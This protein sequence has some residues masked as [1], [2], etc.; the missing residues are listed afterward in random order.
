MTASVC[1][2]GR[3]DAGDSE[4][5]QTMRE[6]FA[7]I[8]RAGVAGNYATWVGHGTLRASTVD[9]AMR[10]PTP[11]ELEAMKA[12]AHEAMEAGA[13]G[14]STGLIYVPS[15]Y[16]HTDEIVALAEVVKE[17]GGVYAS[18]I[19]N[20]RSGLLEAVGGPDGACRHP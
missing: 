5:W 6:Y 20:E 3:D 12:L 13:F 18:H 14:L 19:R 17:Y 15:G 8:E 9:Y 2:R 4:A 16:A 1:A 7:R 10:P 11:E